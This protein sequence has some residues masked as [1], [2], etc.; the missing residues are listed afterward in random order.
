M[1]LPISGFNPM[2]K[3]HILEKIT[4]LQNLGAEKL[5]LSVINKYNSTLKSP[6]NNT[7]KI[8]LN[9]ADDLKGSWTNS[10]STDY[11]SKFKL[12][13]FIKRNFC[14]PYFWTSEKN[15]EQTIKTRTLEYL[16]RTN[17]RLE[18]PQ[19]ITLKEHL[20]QEIYVSTRVSLLGEEFQS[21][22]FIEIESFYLENKDSDQYDKIFNFFSGDLGSESLSYK[23]YA[24][25][26]PL[27]YDY[28]TLLAKRK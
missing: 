3:D 21:N 16:L 4:Q 8:V 28:A 18:H 13:G 24:N 25:H 22:Q 27:G 26:S 19:P 23:Q 6:Q 11:E 10:Y 1:A 14:V 20:A 15:T 2:A 5:I 7:I 9:L 17:Y 12:N